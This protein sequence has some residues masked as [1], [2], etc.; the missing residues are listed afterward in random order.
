MKTNLISTLCLFA[1]LTALPASAQSLVPSSRAEIP[2]AFSAGKSVLPAGTYTLKRMYPGIVQVASEDKKASVFLSV[3]P[4]GREDANAPAR[5][6]F[7]QYGGRYF[8]REVYPTPG[9][10]GGAIRMSKEE[11]ELVAS[12]P[13]HDVKLLLAQK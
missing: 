11:R 10:V 12:T 13:S 1:G 9:A 6:I 2:F 7:H 3:V 4:V 8:L 5:L